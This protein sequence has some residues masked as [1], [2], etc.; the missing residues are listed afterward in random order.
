LKF[1]KKEKK[2]LNIPRQGIVIFFISI[3]MTSAI[4]AGLSNIAYGLTGESRSALGVELPLPIPYAKKSAT[5]LPSLDMSS[6][7][8]PAAST[9]AT[10]CQQLSVKT[11]TKSSGGNSPTYAIDNNYGTFWSN[12]R[13]GSWIKLDFGDSTNI[14][15]LDIAWYKGNL[16][17]YNFNVFVSNDG[18]VFTKVLSGKS[19]GKTNSPEKYNLPSNT[20]GRYVK[21]TV[22]GSN[23]SSQA[24]IS[25]VVAYG[26]NAPTSAAN[27]DDFEGP[28]Y[29]LGDWQTDRSVSPNGKWQAIYA[30]GG[31]DA[32]I[33]KKDSQTGD[34]AMF[35]NPTPSF[36]STFPPPPGQEPDLHSS[37]VISTAKYKDFDLNLDVKTI[38]QLRT[39][40]PNDWENAWVMWNRPQADDDF[41]Y[42][43]YTLLANGG[44]QLEKK[45]NNNQDVAGEIFLAYPDSP[46]IKPNTW[47]NWRIM[48]TGTAT[49]TP[50]IQI[51]IDGV[52]ALN[53]TDNDPSMPRNS[54]TMLNGGSIVLYCEDSD[55][56]FDNVSINPL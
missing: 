51:W 9:Y 36:G 7:S 1:P 28:G 34:N 15:S 5:S 54:A 38:K 56:A 23:K 24:G 55:V 46:S 17:M 12:N 52:Q 18:A 53:Y 37:L 8:V 22:N 27:Y 11:I 19:S 30:Q 29:T 14:C 47:Q 13:L 43:A 26:A 41:H 48:V 39:P 16:R 50:N 35:F 31:P 20:I 6:K 49:G 2:D 45:D 21:I 40:E 33:V 32:V 44:G 42:Y 10:T 4:L 25:E 3:L